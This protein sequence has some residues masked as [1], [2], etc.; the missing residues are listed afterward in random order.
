MTEGRDRYR[1]DLRIKIYDRRAGRLAPRDKLKG[2]LVQLQTQDGAATLMV[3]DAR[4]QQEQEMP[5]GKSFR[6]GVRLNENSDGIVFMY[7]TLESSRRL[8]DMKHD[9]GQG[10]MG[11]LKTE[12]VFISQDRWAKE[13]ARAVGC[14]VLQHPT[15]TWKPD[16]ADRIR[17]ELEEAERSKEGERWEI[18]TRQKEDMSILRF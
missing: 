15:M 6:E 14:I 10:L 2:L 8:N 16:L 9:V 4:V 13:R 3:G 11:W 12:R 18:G 7:T 1:M 17:K 5:D